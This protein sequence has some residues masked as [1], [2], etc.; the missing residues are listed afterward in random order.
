[1]SVIAYLIVFMCTLFLSFAFSLYAFKKVYAQK[2]KE[3]LQIDISTEQMLEIEKRILSLK[4]DKGLDDDID[5]FTFAKKA[6]NVYEGKERRFLGGKARIKEE[7]DSDRKVVDYS[8]RLSKIDR[9]FAFAHECGHVINGDV[10][11]NEK[12]YGHGKPE[13][14]QLADYAAAA[15]LM[16]KNTLERFIETTQ[17]YELD[18][19]GKRKQIKSLCR[20]YC[21]SETM[22]I[23]RLKEIQVIE[24]SVMTV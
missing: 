6:I 8:P 16:P 11:P 22:A 10:I 5:V 21:V 9:V 23:K 15:L 4:Y 24:K 13:E 19:R 14:E 7:K 12:Q 18:T 2:V 17:F 3:E 1:M 20:M